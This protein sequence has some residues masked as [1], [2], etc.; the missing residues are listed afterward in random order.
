MLRPANGRNAF[1]SQ[2]ILFVTVLLLCGCPNLTLLCF[3]LLLPPQALATVSACTQLDVC[4]CCAL[5]SLFCRSCAES[6]VSTFVVMAAFP[7]VSSDDDEWTL[8]RSWVDDGADKRTATLVANEMAF[9]AHQ[10]HSD[11]NF[12]DD[13][14]DK[15]ADPFHCSHASSS[16]KQR[17]GDGA[18]CAVS[19]SSCADAIAAAHTFNAAAEYKDLRGRYDRNK[20]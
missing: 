13:C 12:C 15:E 10:A 8:S 14:D 9:F 2:T 16:S 19:D 18:P 6:L 11:K 1:A 7:V 20:G 17:A 4:T 3:G 5:Q